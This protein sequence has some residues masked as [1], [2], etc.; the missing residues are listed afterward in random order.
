[1][2]TSLGFVMHSPF[3]SLDYH[4]GSLVSLTSR[5]IDAEVLFFQCS[6]ISAEL[7]RRVLFSKSASKK[8]RGAQI[9]QRRTHMTLN[10]RFAIALGLTA[11]LGAA[12]VSAEQLGKAD[13]PFAFEMAGQKWTAGSYS[14]VRQAAG[15]SVLIRNS[16]TWQAA[17]VTPVPAG[18]ARSHDSSMGFHCYGSQCFLSTI[19]FGQ[20]QNVYQIRPSSREKELAQTERPKVTLVAMR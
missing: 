19:Q 11:L 15:G 4:P 3:G 12:V 20:S 6:R 5:A 18:P 2:A 1:M 16:S 13:V 8:R 10:R 17:F 9:H 7:A 14:A